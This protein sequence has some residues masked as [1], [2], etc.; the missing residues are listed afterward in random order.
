[1]RPGCKWSLTFIIMLIIILSAGRVQV[2]ASDPGHFE[3]TNVECGGYGVSDSTCTSTLET[4]HIIHVIWSYCANSYIDYPSLKAPT[5]LVTSFDEVDEVVVAVYPANN[6][7]IPGGYG[8]CNW[9]Y[10][11]T[12]PDL[13]FCNAESTSC[14]TANKEVT[15][16]DGK[17]F[18]RY[19]PPTSWQKK[20]GRFFHNSHHGCQYGCPPSPTY[21]WYV[22]LLSI[23]GITVEESK[24][25]NSDPDLGQRSAWLEIGSPRWLTGTITDPISQ[26][27][28]DYHDGIAQTLNLQPGTYSL[29]V[30]V[31][32]RPTISLSYLSLAVDD[33]GDTFK[34]ANDSLSFDFIVSSPGPYQ[35]NVQNA[36]EVSVTLEYVCVSSSTIKLCTFKDYEFDNNDWASE[37]DVRWLDGRVVLGCDSFIEQQVYFTKGSHEIELHAGADFSV[38]GLFSHFNTGGDLVIQYTSGDIDQEEAVYIELTTPLSS[39]D[40]YTF[41][42]EIPFDGYYTF[43]LWNRDNCYSKLWGLGG[44]KEGDIWLDSICMPWE[45]TNVGPPG[46][47]DCLLVRDSAMA[48][49]GWNDRNVEW[50]GQTAIIRPGGYITQTINVSTTQPITHLVAYVVARAQPG[51][52]L[53]T[54]LGLTSYT[55]TISQSVASDFVVLTTVLPVTLPTQYLLSAQGDEVEI[56]FTCVYDKLPLG[57]WYP[58][59]DGDQVCIEPLAPDM[60][61]GFWSDIAAIL[62]LIWEWVKYIACLIKLWLSRILFKLSRWAGQVMVDLGDWV[63]ELT[64]TLMNWP[65]TILLFDLLMFTAWLPARFLE[66]LLKILSPIFWA[67]DFVRTLVPA[68]FDDISNPDAVSPLELGELE[69][70]FNFVRNVLDNTPLSFFV[71]IANAIL[72]FVFIVWSIKQFSHSNT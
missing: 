33:A 44:A 60:S 8:S 48:G 63:D 72:W 58:G 55:F 42:I 27:E 23:N 57:A 53:I 51:A 16:I 49:W 35:V 20:I 28:L 1:M 24:C 12:T 6:S 70:G 69:D 7:A 13:E 15:N 26:V 64:V 61:G 30:T 43:R 21:D 65:I 4:P 17:W 19:T 36:S 68:L 2:Q 59:A 52:Q 71:N 45:I 3:N 50:T 5:D 31:T 41:S 66:L 11:P 25:I 22:Q 37:G 14:A 40:F 67:W 62:K 47:G 39:T 10:E 32:N 54:A 18:V 34:L 9:P 38:Y 29:S 46:V 56:D